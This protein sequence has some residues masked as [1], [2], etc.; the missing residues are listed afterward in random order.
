VSESTVDYYDR[1]L[2]QPA[3]VM[4]SFLYVAHF[5][6]A[7]HLQVGF[8]VESQSELQRAHL[9]GP[10]IHELHTATFSDWLRRS[11]SIVLNDAKP[12]RIHPFSSTMNVDLPK[13]LD[14]TTEIALNAGRYLPLLLN[15]RVTPERIEAF[16]AAIDSVA[17]A[18]F[19]HPMDWDVQHIELNDGRFVW[20]AYDA[21]IKKVRIGMGFHDERNVKQY[22][23]HSYAVSR[24]G[25]EEFA[26]FHF[27]YMDAPL[28]FMGLPPR[29]PEGLS[30]FLTGKAKQ[31]FAA[32][33]LREVFD[34]VWPRR[35][36]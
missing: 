27:Y 3:R 16:A 18:A 25:A 10:N 15:T 6:G 20:L 19:G 9:P 23:M 35:A 21:T 34:K 8:G 11:G 12:E 33:A 29:W 30:P 31:D 36:D 5:T 24:S 17:V 28:Q 2:I 14:N 1:V 4:K 22:G 32:R 13:K 7:N 26:A